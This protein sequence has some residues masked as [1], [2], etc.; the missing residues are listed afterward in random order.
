[1]KISGKNITFISDKPQLDIL[2]PA[3]AS[4]FVPEW[5][6]TMPGVVD[7]IETV[8]KCIPVLDT[9]N[10]GY[11]IPLPADVMYEPESKQVFSNAIFPLNSDHL[12]V[13]TEQVVISEEFDP[14]PHKWIN[15]WYIKTPKGYSTLFVHPMNRMDLPFYSFS[16][17]VDTDKHP[18]I[19]NFPFVIKSDFTGVIPA[20]TPIIQAIPFKRDSWDSKI[21][22]EGKGYQYLDNAANQNA[23]LAWYKRT[24]WNKKIFR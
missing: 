10:L 19:I 6:R 1:M 21:I 13:Q 20:G 14:Q 16:G 3:P 7:G 11:M 17:V 2:K 18:M 22:D 4:R 24:S 8:K 15:S 5:Y 9:L 23:P 12:A